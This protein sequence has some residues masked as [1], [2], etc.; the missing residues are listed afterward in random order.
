M[1]SHPRILCMG[2][3]PPYGPVYGGGLRTRVTIEALASVGRV[4]FL[5]I[6]RQPWGVDAVAETAG[7]F[8]LPPPQQRSPALRWTGLGLSNPAQDQAFGYTPASHLSEVPCG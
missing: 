4:T 8:E 3:R 2:E 5:P 6:V 1:L 7:R